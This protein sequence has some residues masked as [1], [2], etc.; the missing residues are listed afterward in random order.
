M[1]GKDTA[2]A[3]AAGLAF[4][5]LFLIR[6]DGP[7]DFWWRMSAAVI[8]VGGLG[9]AL[10]KSFAIRLATDLAAGR[11]KKILLGALSA[12]VLYLVFL[13]LKSLAPFVVPSAA[14][15]IG[16][17]YALKTGAAPARVA[18]LILFLIG[19]GE[20]LIWRGLLQARWEDRWGFPRGWLAAAALYAS[21]HIATGNTM[22]V[23]AAAGAG[24]FWG[25]LY[26]RYRSILLNA[27]SHT[28]WD[29]LIFLL[30]PLSP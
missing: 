7:F 8:L 1:P 10:D 22:L 9:V 18:L 19:P 4:F 28:L 11:T 5:L 6:G 14:T 23:L 24:L 16:R 26:H 3:L 20:E 12:A 2:L 27:V 13:G 25:Y 17:V 30:L 29:I 15:Q 21:V